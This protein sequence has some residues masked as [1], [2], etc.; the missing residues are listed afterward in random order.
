MIEVNQKGHEVNGQ[1]GRRLS[2]S[3]LP[4]VWAADI[5]HHPFR[6]HTLEETE[7]A[8][9][10]RALMATNWKKQAAARVLGVKRPTLYARMRK[11]GIPLRSEEAWKWINSQAG[12][13]VQPRG[14][15]EREVAELLR[16]KLAN[17]LVPANPILNEV[18]L[19]S[20]LWDTLTQIGRFHHV[21]KSSAYF[22]R[23]SDTRTY[24][25]SADPDSAFARFA[26]SLVGLGAAHPAMRRSLESIHARA[27]EEAETITEAEL[28]RRLDTCR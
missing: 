17:E 12:L 18:K 22:V 25:I 2:K 9:I 21:G 10:L 11:H 19:A 28:F 26:S 24:T 5:D 27:I 4:P 20:T 13:A 15:G 6:R 1:A 16:Y 23:H 7:R 3:P 8:A 14:E